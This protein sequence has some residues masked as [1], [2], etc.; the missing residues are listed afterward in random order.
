MNLAQRLLQALAR[1]GATEVFGIPG[2]FAL[3]LFREIERSRI[4]PLYTFSHE[5][6]VGFAADAATRMRGGLGVAAVTY[7]AGAFNLVNTVAGAYAERVPLVV[8]SGAPAAHEAA[9]GYQLHHQVKTLDSQWRVFE[10]LTVDRARLDNAR[11]APALIARVLDAALRES[12]PVY[13]EIPRD[14]PQRPCDEVPVTRDP[15]PDAQALAAC[16]DELL[17]R[18]RAAKRPL[19][20]AGVEVRR[21]GLQARVAELARQLAIPVV[22]SFMGR[23]VLTGQD[24]PVLGTYLGLAGCPE[25]AEQV[26]HSD[27]LLLLGVIVSDTNFAVSARRIDL[28]F[29]IQALDGRVV[30]GHHVYPEITLGRLVDAL[31]ERIPPRRAPLSHPPLP[32]RRGGDEAPREDAAVTPADISSAVNRLMRAQGQIPLACDVGDCLFTAM[33]IDPT[34]LI[35][36]GYYASMGY[37]VPAGLGLQAATGQRP[38]ILVGD[39]AFQMTGWELG[40][41]QRYGWDPVVV[42]FN[43]AS[44]EMLRAFEP[45]ANFNALGTWDFA[46]MAAGMGGDGHLVRTCGELDRALTRAWAARGRFQLIDVRIAQGERSPTLSRFVEAVKRLSTSG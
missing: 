44:W 36:P 40:N 14:M 8:L 2:D 11:Q 12:R 26:E 31:L 13:L 35:A 24:V 21:F 10:E 18:L 27:G 34:A 43:N 45:D 1:R 29:A 33:D 15:E 20:M 25:I 42:V 23:G 3:P 39:G 30:M 28:R 38:L 19:L 41:C 16:A 22:T 5:P 46:S 17:Q 9:S 6:A 32:E 7:G 37:G 4:L